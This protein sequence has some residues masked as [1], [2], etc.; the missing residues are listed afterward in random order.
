[1][2]R[3]SVS[4]ED[5]HTSMTLGALNS[6][7]CPPAGPDRYTERNESEEAE[8]GEVGHF[9]RGMFL[10]LPRRRGRLRCATNYA[11]K[12]KLREPRPLSEWSPMVSIEQRVNWSTYICSLKVFECCKFGLAISFDCVIIT[13]RAYALEIKICKINLSMIIFHTHAHMIKKLEL[14]VINV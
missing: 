9:R 6:C 7:H 14:I 4:L 3:S 8:R 13:K 5:S 12:G 1:W 2:V 10:P 11:L